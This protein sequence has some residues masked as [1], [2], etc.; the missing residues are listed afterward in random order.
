MR[1]SLATIATAALVFSASAAPHGGIGKRGD[2]TDIEER[3]GKGAVRGR[4]A[5]GTFLSGALGSRGATDPVKGL[6]PLS[7]PAAFL[8][9]RK[10]DSDSSSDSSDSSDSDDEESNSD[11][12]A[13]EEGDSSSDDSSSGDKETSS[14]SGDEESSSGSGDEES[15]SDSGSSDDQDSS[16]DSDSSSGSSPSGSSNSTGSSTPSSGSVASGTF[17]TAAGESTLSAPMEVTDFDGGMVKFGRGV[18]CTSGEGGGKDAVFNVADGGSLSN[19]IIGAD[20]I[21]GVHCAG[22]CTITNVW[23]EAVC[24]DA[25]TFKGNGDGTVS[26]GG[27]KGAKD[28]VVQHN[29]IG[30]ISISGFY[31]EDFGKLYRSCGNCKEQ[32][33]RHVKID[34]VKASGGSATLVGINSNFG[35]TATITNSCVTGTKVICQEFEGT[36]PGNEPQKI[37]DGPSASCIYTEA[38]VNA[39]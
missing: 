36:S 16:S 37:S 14:G 35:D 5:D 8:K 11:K 6:L 18:S 2:N 30:S 25:L 1:F 26:G 3:G 22:A 39:C 19:V 28:K 4:Y 27:A 20:Q 23:W 9:V 34:G 17:P 33:E 24:E 12:E 31:V 13:E 10:D 7:S 21:E 29:G 38:D 15:S 32:G